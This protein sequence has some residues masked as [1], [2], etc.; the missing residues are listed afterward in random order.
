MSEDVD[1][2]PLCRQC[3]AKCCRY[4]CFQIDKP[5]SFKEF[6]NL[7]WFLLHEGISAH[8]D[9]GNWF[10]AIDNK[11]RRLSDDG[12]CADYANRPVICRQYHTDGC[13]A[14]SG[15]YQYDELFTSAE[16]IAAYARKKLGAMNYDKQWAE[17]CKQAEATASAEDAAARKPKKKDVGKGEGKGK[18]KG[19]NAGRT[20][21]G[22]LAAG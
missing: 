21:V 10:I 20:E 19:K 1:P 16:Q 3:Q 12:R 13:D 9:E 14:T 11:C 8:I 4:F 6:E 5:G 18:N 17:A 7:R 2:F 22:N 15:D